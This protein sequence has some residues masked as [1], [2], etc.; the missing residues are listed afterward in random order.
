M[1]V[2]L[3]GI[4]LI[5]WSVNPEWITNYFDLKSG[6]AVEKIPMLVFFCLMHGNGGFIIR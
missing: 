5:L 3:V 1:P 4:F 2:M 6:N